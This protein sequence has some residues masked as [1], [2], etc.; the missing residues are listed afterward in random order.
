VTSVL[1]FA[2]DDTN[3][4]ND[5]NPSANIQTVDIPLVVQTIESQKTHAGVAYPLALDPD[6]GG[7]GSYTIEP[8]SGLLQ[9][10]FTFSRK[11]TAIPPG[12]IGSGNFVITSLTGTAVF[13]AVRQP[14]P[15]QLFLTVVGVGAENLVNVALSGIQTSDVVPKN[16]LAGDKDVTIGA[17]LGDVTQ[18]YKVGDGDWREIGH[19]LSDPVSGANYLSDLDLNGTIQ[20]SDQVLSQTHTGNSLPPP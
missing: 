9:I 18:S 8:R 20:R 13:V 11:V 10:R 12:P 4:W 14:K 1:G 7:H 19:H 2:V 15:E 16:P 6:P 3:I 5:I 17:L